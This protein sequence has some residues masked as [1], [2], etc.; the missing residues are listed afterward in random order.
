MLKRKERIKRTLVHLDDGVFLGNLFPSDPLEDD[1]KDDIADMLLGSTNLDRDGITFSDGDGTIDQGIK[2][3][4]NGKWD[5]D[6]VGTS[7][8]TTE[9]GDTDL[10]TRVAKSLCIKSAVISSTAALHSELLL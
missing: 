9:G 4:R 2:I 7:V 1:V 10:S 6:L 8:P 5:T 3:D